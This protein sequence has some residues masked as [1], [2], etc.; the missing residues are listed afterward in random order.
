MTGARPDA[1]RA[2]KFLRALTALFGIAVLLML[3]S[4]VADLRASGV[5][6]RAAILLATAG[7]AL[8]GVVA[9]AYVVF[10]VRDIRTNKS[11]RDFGAWSA[12]PTL[13]LVGWAVFALIAIPVR[14]QR[15]RAPEAAQVA[16]QAGARAERAQDAFR[17]KHGRYA[18]RL[19][20]LLEIDST[21]LP[22]SDVTFRFTAMNGSGYA[23]S[24][25]APGSSVTYR[26]TSQKRELERLQGER[27]RRVVPPG[28]AP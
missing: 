24:T 12:L 6:S 13:A 27:R 22:A 20:D 5:V 19:E 9:A 4:E 28:D 21:I 1:I 3:P 7:R 17:A 18:E 14:A 11:W 2:P 10:R 16:H 26:F 8:F 25:R 23:F 15:S